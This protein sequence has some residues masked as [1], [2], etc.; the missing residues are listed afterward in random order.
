MLLSGGEKM[1]K[2]LGNFYTIR[3]VLERAPG[4]AIRLLLLRAQY[5]STLEFSF[6]GLREAQASSTGST[7]RCSGRRRRRRRCRSRC[8]TRCATT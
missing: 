5:R 2:S 3:D 4:E 1:S 7:A 8:W 6:E